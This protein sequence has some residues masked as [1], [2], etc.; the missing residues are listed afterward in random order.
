MKS[1]SLLLITAALMVFPCTAQIDISKLEDS[2][3]TLRTYQYDKTQGVDLVWVETQVG[4]AAADKAVR[5]RVEDKLIESLSQAKTDDARQFLC[6]Q[7]R[8][9]G[10]AQSVPQLASMLTDPAISHM[11]R[12][13]LGRIDVPCAG[14]AMHQA[15][16][17]TSGEIKAG[18]INT[19]VQMD[20][21]EAATVIEP[22]VNDPSKAVSIAAIRGV[23]HFGGPDAVKSLE[24]KRPSASRDVVVEIDDALL[25]CAHRFVAHHCIHPQIVCLV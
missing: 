21:A 3:A 19:L 15:L 17:R 5:S 18:L 9:I 16:G 11:A 2:I 25:R 23:G 7:L 14:Q 20:H 13:A 12:Y 6:R 22:L 8:T 4:M 10:T 1:K 24:R